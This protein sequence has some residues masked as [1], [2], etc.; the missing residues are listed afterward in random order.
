MKVILVEPLIPQNTGNILRT[1]IAVGAS[2]LLLRPHFS[3][4]DSKM[5][6]AGL[7][8]ARKS[9]PQEIESLDEELEQSSSFFFFSSKKHKTSH[10]LLTSYTEIS[11]EKESLL[12]FGNEEKGLP[13]SLWN[14]FPNQFVTIPMEKECRCLNLAKACAIAL[15][16]V[17]RQLNAACK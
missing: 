6:R 9:P 15:F 10:T 16:E 7:D 5:R 3:L 8:Y 12:I 11:Y 2:L 14:R 17:R 13:E 4:S 1:C